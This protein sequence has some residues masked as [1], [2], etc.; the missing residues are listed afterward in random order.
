MG[1]FEMIEVNNLTDEKLFS[2]NK[3]Y[4]K[5]KVIKKF[6]IM[7]ESSCNQFFTVEKVSVIVLRTLLPNKE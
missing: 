4:I 6:L 2:T 3:M 1:D 5:E 7:S